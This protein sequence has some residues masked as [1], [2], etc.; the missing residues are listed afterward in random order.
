LKP[1]VAVEIGSAR[2]KS[3]CYVGMALKQNESGHLYAVDPH[4]ST[5]WNDVNSVD[6]FE[7]M[8][9]N[10]AALGLNDTV[11]IV[12]EFSD[13]A[14]ANIPKP[15]DMIFIDGDH[16]Y[17]GVKKDWDLY[18]PHLSEFGYVVFHDTIW[19]RRPDSSRHRSDMGVPRFVD[20]LRKAGYPVL[21]I[22]KDCG[23]SLVQTTKGGVPLSKKVAPVSCRTMDSDESYSA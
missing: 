10:L 12:R 13:K 2:G 17:E 9:G 16:S 3:A 21:T 14:V 22:D 5:E 20:E 18:S 15:I 4:T 8:R 6:T 19:D 11:T 1:K 23:V 7:I